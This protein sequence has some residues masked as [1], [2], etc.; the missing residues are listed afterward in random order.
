MYWCTQCSRRLY[1]GEWNSHYTVPSYVV[2]QPA[3]NG[4]WTV[5]Y[6]DPKVPYLENRIMYLER[7]VQELEAKSA[8]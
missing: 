4:W 3:L 1:A 8:K 5:Y 2:P 7:R 6:S